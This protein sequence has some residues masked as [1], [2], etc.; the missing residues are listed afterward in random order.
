MEW[1]A[2]LRRMW[3][4]LLVIAAVGVAGCVPAR[5]RIHNAVYT[6]ERLVDEVVSAH[7]ACLARMQDAGEV[8]RAPFRTDGCS[9]FPDSSW[10]QCCVE[11]DKIYWCG[12]TA[13]QRKRA[14]QELRR[15]I[16][17]TGHP[18]VAAI[19]YLG[20]RLGGHPIWP[21]PWRWGYGRGWPAWYDEP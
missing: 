3:L 14:D 9:M 16:R 6:E 1:R 19:V 20:T 21:L 15:C 5:H 4:S 17:E 13:E 2:V 7:A 11:H 18:N 8:P 10:Q 12:G